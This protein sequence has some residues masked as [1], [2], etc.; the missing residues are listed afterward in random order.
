VND[1][2]DTKW[3]TRDDVDQMCETGICLEC[4]AEIDMCGHADMFGIDIVIDEDDDQ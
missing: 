2:D 4:G 1:D 3:W